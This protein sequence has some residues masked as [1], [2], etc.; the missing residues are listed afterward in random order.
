MN[1]KIVGVLA[2][3]MAALMAAVMFWPSP[4]ENLPVVDVASSRQDEDVYA[5]SAVIKPLALPTTEQTAHSGREE[6]G[7]PI[8]QVGIQVLN[9]DDW[10]AV[11]DTE[12]FYITDVIRNKRPELNDFQS[13]D[14][15]NRLHQLPSVTTDADGMA[16]L[17]LPGKI[18]YLYCLSNQAKGM[19]K[20]KLGSEPITEVDY[21]R[22][23]F[24]HQQIELQVTVQRADGKPAAAVPVVLEGTFKP[25]A[26]TDQSGQ[27]QLTLP[28]KIF[29]DL[30]KQGLS[31][32]LAVAARLPLLGTP[33]GEITETGA[34]YFAKIQLPPYGGLE[35]HHIEPGWSYR[36]RDEHFQLVNLEPREQAGATIIDYDF[37]AVNSELTLLQAGG[38]SSVSQDQVVLAGIT[39][40]A[41]ERDV[42]IVNAKVVPGYRLRGRLLEGAGG[43]LAQSPLTLWFLN[44]RGESVAGTTQALTNEKGEFVIYRSGAKAELPASQSIWI[45]A[46][47]EDFQNVEAGAT[48]YLTT[49]P[50]PATQD[51]LWLGELQPQDKKLL[52]SGRVFDAL[53][54]PIEDVSASVERV[55]PGEENRQS[56]RPT[57]DEV[58]SKNLANSGRGEFLFEY[59][60][61]PFPCEYIL[62]VYVMDKEW[63]EIK[64]TP[65]TEDLVVQLRDTVAVPFSYQGFPL[66]EGVEFYLFGADGEEIKANRSFFPQPTSSSRPKSNQFREVPVG[67]YTFKAIGFE[68]RVLKEIPGVLVRKGAEYPA[69][70]GIDLGEDNSIHIY[71]D[72]PM[73]V[74][75]A[76]VFRDQ[77]VIYKAEGQGFTKQSGFG[78]ALGGVVIPNQ[79]TQ[80]EY[81]LAMSGCKP[82]SLNGRADGDR[83]QLEPYPTIPVTIPDFDELADQQ[84]FWVHLVSADAS[85]RNLQLLNR[86]NFRL[87]TE[88]E[89]LEFTIPGPGYYIPIWEAVDEFW[90]ER[91]TS[92]KFEWRGK[93][94]HLD[95]ER[96]AN[97]ITLNVPDEFRAKLV[98]DSQ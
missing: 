67:T 44:E 70:T 65:G 27:A 16:V 46:N 91:E 32:S 55:L 98:G 20:T 18:A 90:Y 33:R 42:V 49:M 35:I 22:V 15:W 41:E 88:H 21:R 3:I 56:S 92:I 39:G 47:G 5:T 40:P 64:V 59:A 86:A 66:T 17:E 79:W 19:L 94:I 4:Q 38:G 54:D 95:P 77:L 28:L 82:V 29:T 48:S 8:H 9:H 72:V 13:K 34:D 84:A 81:F 63:V 31:K 1:L 10:T 62:S 53:G 68:G 78:Y 51:D 69:L 89:R 7:Y 52:V 43:P 23:L 71:L 75:A 2:V 74:L 30:K 61:T 12:V 58:A 45:L 93:P 14:G 37:V 83:I 97:G 50:I 87:S 6:S 24:V 26:M 25:V 11:A 96:D 76:H 60:P 73:E 57:V 80:A 36:I 85:N